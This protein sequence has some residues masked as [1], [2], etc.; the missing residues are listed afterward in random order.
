LRPPGNGR[1]E[2]VSRLRPYYEHAGITI[3][4]GDCRDILPGLS[5]EAIITD[6][7]WPGC[8]HIFPGIDARALL[9]EALSLANVN[10]VVLELGCNSD[11]RFLA[12]VP[13]RFKF[14]RVCYLEYAVIGYIGRILRDADVA[15]A[16]GE[17]PRS[18]PGKR[19]LPGRVIATRSNGDKGWKNKGRT[20]ER[21]AY[22]VQQMEH[23]TRRLIQH[24][25]WL[26]KWFAGESVV[27]P[28]MGSGTTAIAC[29]FLG[30]P[31]V[32]IEIEERYCEI[33]AKRLAQEVLPFEAVTERPES[34]QMKIDGMVAKT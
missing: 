5:A 32:G 9:G 14:L 11:V 29:K 30:V 21:V 1:A 18:A 10:R 8:E 13:A 19:C 2:G 20:A 34:V 3:Y 23:P 28:F 27:D 12:C 22:S 4:H 6:P 17:P 33:A 26:C 31:F 15:Y 24:V 25:Q 16:F 7:I